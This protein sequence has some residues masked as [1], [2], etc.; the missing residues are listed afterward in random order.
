MF[1][2][3]RHI[4]QVVEHMYGILITLGLIPDST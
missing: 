3:P 2:G 1:S 4:S